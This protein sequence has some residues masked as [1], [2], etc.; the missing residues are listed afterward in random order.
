MD[1]QAADNEKVDSKLRSALRLGVEIPMS[2]GLGLLLA[3]TVQIGI[4]VNQFDELK[5][6]MQEIKATNQMN[7]DKLI[8]IEQTNSYQGE[9]IT[10]HENRIRNVERKTKS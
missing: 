6:A 5:R 7:G 4:S 10:D 3:A 8:R 1:Q 9:Q 2:I